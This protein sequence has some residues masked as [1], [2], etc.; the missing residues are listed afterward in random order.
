MMT[1]NIAFLATLAVAAAT[2][3]PGE[4]YVEIGAPPKCV[5]DA[6]GFTHVYYIEAM[7]V[8]FR[9]V[10][11]CRPAPMLCSL[12]TPLGLLTP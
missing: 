10:P 11:H 5:V 2:L 3:V 7:H 12:R 8:S 4:H 9:P 6:Q 1:T